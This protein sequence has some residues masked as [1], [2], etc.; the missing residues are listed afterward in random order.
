MDKKEYDRLRYL[1][2]K[3]T[4]RIQM[5]ESYIREKIYNPVG[6]LLRRIKTR[7]KKKGLEFNLEY[8]DIFIPEVCPILEIPLYQGEGSLGTNS[9]SL[10]R[11]D[12]SKGYVKGNVQVV[13]SRANSLKRD[14]SLEELEKIVEYIRRLS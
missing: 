11:I 3:D 4:V 14:A 6:Q 2:R 8:D 9:P 1:R 10:D 5:R 13:S 12:N 7:A